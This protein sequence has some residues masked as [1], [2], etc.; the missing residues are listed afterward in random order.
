MIIFK[1]FLKSP[2]ILNK[3][4]DRYPKFLNI[5]FV[6]SGI[7]LSFFLTEGSEIGLILSYI[8]IMALLVYATYH[9]RIVSEAIKNS[10][11]GSFYISLFFAIV[12]IAIYLLNFY[13]SNFM[14][15]GGFSPTI[16][17]IIFNFITILNSYKNI[18]IIS[19]VI[20]IG[21]ISTYSLLVINMLIINFIN[22]NLKKLV[23]DLF[24]SFDFVDKLYIYKI[25]SLFAVSI[26]IIYNIT[27]VFYGAT[28]NGSFVNFN[29][30]YTT[31]TTYLVASNVYL[32]ISA[33]ENDIRQPLFGLFSA[34]F[35]VIA[36]VC[37][38]ILFF[39]PNIYPIIMSII[40][41][42]LLF[43][44]Y[45]MIS[46]MIGLSKISKMFFLTIISFSYPTLLFSINMEQYVFATFWL[47][48]FLYSYINISDG[49][50]LLYIASTG[51]LITSGILFPLISDK[52]NLK[53]K[54]LE[55]INTIIM[56]FVVAIACGRFTLFKNAIAGFE[57]LLIFTGA[58]LGFREKI[59][60]YLN[61]VESCLIKPNA[62]VDSV[63]HSWISYQLSDANDINWFGAIIIFM[64]LLGFAINYKHKFAKI[65]VVWFAYSFLL[66]CIIGWG[67]VENGLIL[68]SL[69]FSWAIVSLVFM[70][71][72]K[73][74]QSVGKIKYFVYAT[75]IIP[76]LII[77]LTGIW[78][79]IKFGINYYH[80]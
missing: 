51:S 61:F 18:A 31:D 58:S 52:K 72:E 63:S 25:F 2:S 36:T 80:T 57:H 9:K 76:I 35:A 32:N 1:F 79:L 34:P 11:R 23:I 40:Q 49:R 12:F 10:S 66:L 16:F 50:N 69:Y 55:I 33:I 22:R 4:Y 53:E 62:R 75:I 48:L 77:N 21:I 41:V 3:V 64:A 47:I 19:L 59:L 60:Q 42:F 15:I 46:R 65:C 20:L 5:F 14:I 37:S 28:H 30:V 54:V 8:L 70:F 29:V 38:I 39:I 56:F 68:Y 45:L 43:I 24:C 26:I 27:N 74:L 71:M 73:M 7:L 17:K 6:F 44:S 78:D 13:K 67:T